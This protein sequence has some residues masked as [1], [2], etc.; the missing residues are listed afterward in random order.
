MWVAAV[1]LLVILLVFFLLWG[2]A[3]GE[4]MSDWYL[5]QMAMRYSDPTTFIYTGNER[6]VSGMSARDY[7]LENKANYLNGAAPAYFEGNQRFVDHT[8][9][10][11][12][13]AEYRPRS[14]TV[15]Y[16]DAQMAS[17]GATPEDQVTALQARGL[18]QN[19]LADDIL[20]L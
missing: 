18:A 17:K 8:D 3:R 10:L 7:Y 19:D 9:Y 15:S 5:D 13:P 4:G 12:M 14:R 2:G 6:D 20:T 1:I 11:N 16:M